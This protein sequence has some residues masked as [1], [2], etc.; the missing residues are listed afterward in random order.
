VPLLLALCG[1]VPAA[2]PDARG[3]EFF[4]NKIRPVLVNNCYECHWA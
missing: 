3:I 2:A 4:E 1:T